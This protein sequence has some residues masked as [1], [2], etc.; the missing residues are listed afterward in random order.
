MGA[1]LF[2][3]DASCYHYGGPLALGD[4]EETPAGCTVTCPWHR[5][6]ID[7]ATG[8]SIHEP[9]DHRPA[10]DADVPMQRTH[11]VR[12]DEATGHVQVR[13]RLDGECASDDY[14]LKGLF[15]TPE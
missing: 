4:I 15:D 12:V 9:V 13:L 7:L 2:A 6:K 3:L 1:R 5:Y 14:A 8:H 11:D 10:S